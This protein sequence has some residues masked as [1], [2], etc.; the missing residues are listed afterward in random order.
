MQK[1]ANIRKARGVARGLHVFHGSLNPLSSELWRMAILEPKE[2]CCWKLTS[3]D[4]DSIGNVSLE[5][6][7]GFQQCGVQDPR[8]SAEQKSGHDTAL[9]NTPR[10]LLKEITLSVQDFWTLNQ[11]LL[12]RFLESTYKTNLTSTVITTPNTVSPFQL[13]HDILDLDLLALLSEAASH[14]S[15]L[16]VQAVAASSDGSWLRVPLVPPAP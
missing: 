12:C 9:N 14:S 2:P 7:Q 3:E 5:R 10:F 16:F 8:F 13:K 1:M 6:F 11:F 4:E 15:Q